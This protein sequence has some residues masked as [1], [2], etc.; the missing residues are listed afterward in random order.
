MRFLQNHGKPHEKRIRQKHVLQFLVF[1]NKK[2][3]KQSR[4]VPGKKQ[5]LGDFRTRSEN[6]NKRVLKVNR[7]RGRIERRYVHHQHPDKDKKRI[8]L[9]RD[10]QAR[11]M[12][13]D[14]VN[15]AR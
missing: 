15:Y 9:K 7:C 8:R 10:N 13:Y 3:K 2:K 11:G 14:E 1:R 6:E 4:G 5:V 12:V